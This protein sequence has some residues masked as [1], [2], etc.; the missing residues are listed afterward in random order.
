MSIP[1]QYDMKLRFQ[2]NEHS[3]ISIPRM[4]VTFDA[5]VNYIFE[6]NKMYTT[7]FW[8]TLM[9]KDVDEGKYED[10]DGADDIVNDF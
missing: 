8:V 3:F 9:R 5:E 6:L 10:S 2:T 1:F 7:P 4:K